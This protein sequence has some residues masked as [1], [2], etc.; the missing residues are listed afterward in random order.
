MSLPLRALP[1]LDGS[2]EAAVARLAA[3]DVD[4]RDVQLVDLL[5]DMKRKLESAY[6]ATTE[7]S[8]AEREVEGLQNQ[9]QL[10]TYLATPRW[11][12]P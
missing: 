1:Q 11:G 3:M 12:R 4:R 5:S 2:R 10:L 7:G 9:H 6:N 8:V